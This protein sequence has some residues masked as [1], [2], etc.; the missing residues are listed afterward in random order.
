MVPKR[1]QALR[2]WTLDG[3]TVSLSQAQLTTEI[4]V[5]RF[6]LCSVL[7]KIENEFRAVE[8]SNVMEFVFPDFRAAR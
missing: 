8:W 3:S 7:G 6:P 2:L 4:I 1:E 5:V